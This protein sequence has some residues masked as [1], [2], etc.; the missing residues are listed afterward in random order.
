[1]GPQVFGHRPDLPPWT[2]D[3]VEAQRLLGE[4]GLAA[5][6]SVDLDVLD[7][8]VGRAAGHAIADDLAPLDI[9]VHPRP[10]NLADLV[11]RIETRD[12]SAYLMPW[13]GTSGDA[14]TSYEYLLHTPGEGGLG[15]DNGGG[16]SNPQL[17]RLLDEASRRIR[18]AERRAMLMSAAWLIRDDVPVIPLFRRV[19]IYAVARRLEFNP[20]LDREIRAAEMRWRR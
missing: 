9:R 19:D 15:V 10:S 8:E 5:G 7:S 12:T 20:R 13:I 2:H 6:F 4:A 18:T 17:D 11:K 3:P 16:Y 1:M 14:G